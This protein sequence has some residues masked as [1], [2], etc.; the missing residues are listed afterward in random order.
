MDPSDPTILA[1]GFNSVFDRAVDH[2]G[3]CVDDDSCESLEALARLFTNCCCVEVWR[4]LFPPPAWFY[5]VQEGWRTKLS[6]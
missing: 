4:H 6:Y 2:W 5:Q 1:G 3:S